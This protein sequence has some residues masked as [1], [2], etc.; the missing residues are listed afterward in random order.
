MY[1]SHISTFW[2]E[3][4]ECWIPITEAQKAH[5]DNL[6]YDTFYGYE[7][8]DEDLPGRCIFLDQFQRHFQRFLHK[9]NSSTSITEEYITK[10]REEAVEDVDRNADELICQ[11][12]VD[13]IACL[14]PFKHLGRYE[15][16]FEY[17]HNQYLPDMG[18][19]S[20]P[21]AEKITT[22]PLLARF[23]YDTYKKYQTDVEISRNLIKLN[24]NYEPQYDASAICE[25]ADFP[26]SLAGVVSQVTHAV[27]GSALCR[28]ADCLRLAD[29]EP[30]VSL[31][32]GVDSM[33]A[34]TLLKALGKS[35]SAVNIIYG[36]RAQSHYEFCFLI[37]YCKRL[38]IS[39][40]AYEIPYIKR[41]SVERKFYESV[42]RDIRFGVY[43]VVAKEKKVLLGHIQDDLVEN[44]WTNFAKGHHL[45][46]LAKMEENEEQMGVQ[47]WRPLLGITK[48]LIYEVAAELK[49]PHLKNTTPSW[50]NRGKFR[51]HFYE[52][53][54]K[55][56]GVDVDKKL[57]EVANIFKSQAAQIDRLVYQQVYKSWDIESATANIRSALV[58]ELDAN[59]WLKIFEHICHKYLQVCRP[60]I[61][62]MR[63]FIRRLKLYDGKYMKMNIG[64]NVSINLKEYMLQFDVVK[65]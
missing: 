4:P 6:I 42:T 62:A 53:T 32:G 24:N 1:S 10:C 27:P 34:L 51:E 16:I 52:E 38:D 18:W 31:S 21:D 45:D 43:R 60:S 65:D 20:N 58:A 11:G 37:D 5:A 56:Y 39:L 40:I 64:K 29:A 63:E 19:G 33:V 44:I 48:D 26:A 50:S 3:H 28:L 25:S 12:E 2:K 46:N 59:G 22:Y 17:L 15:F 54:H 61:H 14:M 36:N 30:V 23:Y 49:I 47:L 41:D 57:L 55:Q 9:Q 35:P 13:L 7:Y 8:E